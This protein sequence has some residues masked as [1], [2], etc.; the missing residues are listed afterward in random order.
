[1]TAS[2]LLLKGLGTI[3]PSLTLPS[4]MVPSL[5]LAN[6]HFDLLHECDEPSSQNVGNLPAALCIL[7]AKSNGILIAC[8]VQTKA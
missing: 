1:M 2:G 5:Q 4:P 7:H 3:V 8:T 6:L